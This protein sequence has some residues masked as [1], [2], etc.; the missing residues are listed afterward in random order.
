MTE[1]NPVDGR[2]L[3]GVW[4]GLYTYPDGISVSFVATLIEAGRSVTGSVHEPCTVGGS[5][6]ETISATLSGSRSD[7]AVRFLKTYE[8]TNPHYGSVHYEG[9]LNHDGTEVEG[10]WTVPR[11]WSGKFLMIRSGGAA[12]TVARKSAVR[13]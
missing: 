3:T 13:A 10:R 6:N 7:S 9:T 5:P 11:N 2:N 12:E 1:R 4:H 8:G